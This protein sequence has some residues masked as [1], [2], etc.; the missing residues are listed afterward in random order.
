MSKKIYYSLA[1]LSILLLSLIQHTIT[2]VVGLNTTVNDAENDVYYVSLTAEGENIKKGNYHDE[3]DIVKFEINNQ[4][5]NLTFAGNI[6][7]WEG[8]D[9]VITEAVM[10]LHPN[11]DMELYKEGNM[12]YP[13]YAIYYDNWSQSLGY[14]VIFA[15]VYEYLGDEDREFWNETAGWVSNNTLALDIG[16]ASDKS[17]IANVP[18]KAYN[19]TNNT[20]YIAQSIHIKYSPSEIKYYIDIAPEEYML[21]EE[22]EEVIPGYNLFII[23]GVLVG[24]SLIIVRKHIKRK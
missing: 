10:V 5:L 14:R 8:A 9:D 21:L 11:F 15:H 13:Y 24:I 4:N 12:T 19:I 1:F 17:I 6:N 2:P 3:I 18:P 16:S 20:T 7:D 23:V 22:T